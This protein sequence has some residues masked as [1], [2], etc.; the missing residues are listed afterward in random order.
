MFKLKEIGK[1]TLLLDEKRS[2]TLKA[3]D[4]VKLAV[5]RKDNLQEFHKTHEDIFLK[6]GATLSH[7]LVPPEHQASL[8]AGIANARLKIIEGAG[9]NV[10]SERS[11]DVIQEVTRFLA[12]ANPCCA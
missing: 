12:S 9:H 4:Q 10:H 3:I 6:I 8:A 5:V 1:I 2:A 7:G 11:T